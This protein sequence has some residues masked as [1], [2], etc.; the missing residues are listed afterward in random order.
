[1]LTSASQANSRMDMPCAC[2]GAG[3]RGRVL[4]GDWA[5]PEL[6]QRYGRHFLPYILR[7]IDNDKGQ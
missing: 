7:K 5:R 1:M 2:L 3:C 6:Q 4:G